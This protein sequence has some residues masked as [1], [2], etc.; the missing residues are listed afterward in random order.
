MA[1]RLLDLKPGDEVIVPAYTFVSTANAF[2]LRGAKI[3]FADSRVDHPN[4]DETKLEDLITPKT[5]A[6]VCVHYAGFPCELNTLRQLCD[7]H[8]LFLI[9]DAAQAIHSFYDTGNGKVAAG[10]V[11]DFATFSF[12]D[13]KNIH[14]GEGGALVINNPEFYN[15]A[16]ILWEKGTNK[17][18]FLRGEVK[19]YEWVDIGSSFVLSEINAAFLWAQLQHVEEV[20]QK[21]Q[22]LWKTYYNA[23]CD[24]ELDIILPTPD[25]KGNGHIF[26]VLLR[27]H[28]RLQTVIQAFKEKGIHVT[29]HYQSLAKSVTV[30]MDPEAKCTRAS[31]FETHLLRLP[32]CAELPSSTAENIACVFKE[33]LALN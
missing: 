31:F 15:R 18:A 7:K 27:Q 12:H 19:R 6:I 17:N 21:R 25:Q 11:G 29:T 20:T 13:T 22:E 30:G 5:K 26:F 4:M 24:A 33:I 16:D 10:S 2:L 14:C 28:D 8:N 9:E 32:L 23:L 3:V 1:A